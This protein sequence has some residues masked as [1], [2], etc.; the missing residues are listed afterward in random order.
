MTTVS[1]TRSMQS[2]VSVLTLIF[3]PW[4]TTCGTIPCTGLDFGGFERA[5]FSGPAPLVLLG[6]SLD[7]FHFHLHERA[8]AAAAVNVVTLEVR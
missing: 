2:P 8:A 1:Q 4:L 3:S 7:V 6:T 5:G